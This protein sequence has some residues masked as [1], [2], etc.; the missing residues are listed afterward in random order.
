MEFKETSGVAQDNLNLDSNCSTY[1]A[2][3]IPMC[4]SVHLKKIS[5]MTPQFWFIASSPESG[6]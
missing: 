6:W 1:S 2:C 3:T 5:S 4:L